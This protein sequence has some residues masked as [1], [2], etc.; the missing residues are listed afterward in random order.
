MIKSDQPL[1]KFNF[2]PSFLTDW[3]HPNRD[4]YGRGSVAGISLVRIQQGRW[5]LQKPLVEQIL[6][7]RWGWWRPRLPADLPIARLAWDGGEGKRL[8]LQVLQVVLWLGFLNISLLFRY[9]YRQ[10]FW[11]LLVD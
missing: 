1:C 11:Q 8:V 7:T 6:P 4:C 10:W 2:N 3:F 5:L 9:G